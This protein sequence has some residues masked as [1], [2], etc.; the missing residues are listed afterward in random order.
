MKILYI[1][2]N[3]FP[4]YEALKTERNQAMLSVGP[5]PST[6]TF[7]RLPFAEQMYTS[8]HNWSAPGKT[9]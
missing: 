1:L 2:K 8:P 4:Q 6:L 7:L 5:V 3:A 9:C